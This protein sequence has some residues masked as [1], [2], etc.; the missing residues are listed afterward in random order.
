MT[1]TREQ[2]IA[3]KQ[4][5]EDRAWFYYTEL[6]EQAQERV[7][8][9]YV[10]NMDFETEYVVDDMLTVCDLLGV[11]TS[12]RDLHWSGFS[13]QGDGASFVGEYRYEKGSV[14]AIAAHAPQDVELN[15]IATRLFAIQRRNFYALSADVRSISDYC[16]ENTVSV[17]VS[18]GRRF[19]EANEDQT[20]EITECLKDLMRWFYKQLQA[21]YEYQTGD[22]AK[23]YLATCDETPYDE[24]GK[25]WDPAAIR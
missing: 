19:C 25:E 9:R 20:D 14:K 12:M 24:N 21:E 8:T 22:G 2:L 16:H 13:S 11:T 18:D 7:F 17:E 4:A 1:A 15:R 3:A 23:E 5:L 6:S 10:S